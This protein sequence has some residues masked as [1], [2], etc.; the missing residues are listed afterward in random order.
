MTDIERIEQ[1]LD[2]ILAYLK[3]LRPPMKEKILLYDWFETWYRTYKAPALKQ[4]SLRCIRDTI[5]L[6][7]KPNIPN[8]PLSELTP[9][10]LQQCLNGIRSSRMAEYSHNTLTDCMRRAYE[11]GYTSS[12]LMDTVPKPKHQRTIGHALTRSE[13]EELL[14]SLKELR[15]GDIFAFYLYSGCRRSEALAVKWC[16]VDMKELVLHIPGTKTQTSDRYIPILPKLRELIK[17][18]PHK[19]DHLFPFSNS[20]VIREYTKLRKLCSFKFTIHSLRHTY[21]TRLHEQGIDDKVIQK[22]AG[23]SSVVTTQRIYIHVLDE[24]EKAQIGKL[25]QTNLF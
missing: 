9:L 11:Q 5:R 19:E 16:D 13:Q 10:H 20:T 17:H 12:N 15:H 25:L 1:K 4:N 18:L 6:H 7:I 8:L 3:D 24:Q 21:I 23:H 2:A 22:W 14:R